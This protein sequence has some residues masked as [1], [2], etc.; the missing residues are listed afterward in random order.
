M[1]PAS[2]TPITRCS[3]LAALRERGNDVILL[4][5]RHGD[6]PLTELAQT[7]RECIRRAL[8]EQLD[9]GDVLAAGGVGRGALATRYALAKMERES[10]EHRSAY[11]FSYNETAPTPEETNALSEVGD[12][13][14]LPRKLGMVSGEFKSELSLDAEKGPFDSAKA[15]APNPGGPLITNEL[16]S[17]L[18]GYLTR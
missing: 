3:L 14:V 4:G 1:K 8:V 5:Y 18:V 7:V 16:G 2:I 12:W 11:L 10:T 13:P 15:G 17:W 9:A 6:A